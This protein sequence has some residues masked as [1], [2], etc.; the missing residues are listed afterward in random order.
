M[1]RVQ[2]RRF[3][4]LEY[5]ALGSMTK[6]ICSSCKLTMSWRV[7]YLQEKKDTKRVVLAIKPIRTI[8]F[9]EEQ[10]AVWGP[11]S[12]LWKQEAVINVRPDISR[13]KGSTPVWPQLENFQFCCV[14]RSARMDASIQKTSCHVLWLRGLILHN[15][16]WRGV[17][18]WVK[19][20]RY[21][22][23]FGLE[24]HEARRKVTFALYHMYN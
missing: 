23:Y 19:R 15:S 7:S 2:G 16:A 12:C 14:T 3:P 8:H 10:E 11:V 21:P 17:V 13:F 18:N 6:V 9:T 22:F 4:V 1:N 5:N 20:L 24:E